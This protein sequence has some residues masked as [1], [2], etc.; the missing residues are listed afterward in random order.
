[1]PI[2][3][4]RPCWSPPQLPRRPSTDKR[5]MTG[6]QTSL[7][8]YAPVTELFT[9]RVCMSW[10]KWL[11]GWLR[12]GTATTVGQCPLSGSDCPLLFFGPLYIVCRVPERSLPHF[13]WTMGPLCPFFHKFVLFWAFDFCLPWCFCSSFLVIK[14]CFSL[15]CTNFSMFHEASIIGKLLPPLEHTCNVRSRHEGSQ[16]PSERKNILSFFFI[17]WSVSSNHAE[18]ALKKKKRKK[19]RSKSIPV[20]FSMHFLQFITL[21]GCY[22]TFVFVVLIVISRTARCLQSALRKRESETVQ[23]SPTCSL[24]S[25]D[26]LK[27]MGIE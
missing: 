17:F 27:E 24:I 9:E 18:Q 11:P 26:H 2:A 1:M 20:P 7:R 15:P 14:F 5:A 16:K 4:S 12:S 21:R 3:L 6:V 8:L 25:L 22:P 10:R 23:A 13:I 19:G